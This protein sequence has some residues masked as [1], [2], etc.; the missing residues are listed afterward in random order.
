MRSLLDFHYLA[1]APELND[2]DCTMLITSL[3]AFHDNK[4][5]II[6]AGGRKGKKNAIDNWY[7]PK[8]ELLQSVIPSIQT[9][10]APAQW[11]ANVTEHA[12]I[13]VVKNPAC[14]SNNVNIDPQI[15]CQLDRLEKCLRFK[16]ATSLQEVQ[17]H[18]QDE[19]D[20]TQLFQS[21]AK[22]GQPKRS[23]ADYFAKAQELLVSPCRSVPIPLCTSIVC[24]TAIN[25]IKDPKINRAPI[26]TIATEH[27]IPDLHGAI[28]DYLQWEVQRL[29]HQV[30]GQCHFTN[31]C[32]LPFSHLA[33]WHA[34]RLQQ[35]PFH[36][37]GDL[38]PT[39][40]VIAAPPSTTWCYGH[41]DPV[42]FNTDLSKEWP[43]SGLEG[44]SIFTTSPDVDPTPPWQAIALVKYN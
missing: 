3:Q 25:I 37:G 14:R 29:S 34:V 27:N 40:T 9:S 10:G 26:D 44:N 4:A 17:D 22:L 33:V 41:Y 28:G 6:T 39:H 38:D 42:L 30:A 1:Q 43:T 32:N 12:H 31:T 13:V 11:M 5:S 20:D 18:H 36:P 19:D 2:N 7:I 23:P 24:N 21:V 16:L 15:C 35:R 8:L